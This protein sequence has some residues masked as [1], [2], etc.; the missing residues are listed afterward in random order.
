MSRPTVVEVYDYRK[1][2]NEAMIQFLESDPAQEILSII[3]IGI[4][5]EQQHQELLV[6]D[7]KYILGNQ[8]VIPVYGNNYP[9]EKE[10]SSPGWIACEEGIYTIGADGNSF[11]YDNEM[12]A[13]KVFLESFQIR[14]TLVTNGEFLEFMIDCGYDRHLLWH[15]EGLDFIHQ[16][17][18]QSPLFWHHIDD[19]WHHYTLAGLQSIDLELPVQHLSLYEAYAFSEWAGCR[20]PT[21]FEWEGVAH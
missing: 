8:P 3:E 16:E 10:K 1:Y 14:D 13:H 21:E 19:Q 20:I 17:E 6:Y 18:I 4:N 5:H 15:A 11:C 2:V 12:Q 9:P 7:L